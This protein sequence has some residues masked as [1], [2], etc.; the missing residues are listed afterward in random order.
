MSLCARQ[1]VQWLLALA[2]LA[3]VC[4]GAPGQAPPPSAPTTLHVK[5]SLLQIPV[6]ILGP[7]HQP[8]PPIDGS[9]FSVQLGGDKPFRPRIVRREG[10]DPI[11]LAIL[12]DGSARDS[13]V[14]EMAAA[15][16]ALAGRELHE[17]DRVAVYAMDGCK[18]RRML[19]LAEPNAVL[20]RSSVEAALT[21][22]PYDRYK[23][24][25]E[26]CDSP[27]GLWDSL[28]WVTRSLSGEPGRRV[29]LAVSNGV[30]LGSHVVPELLRLSATR[31]G[32]A[33]FS[34]AERYKVP[35]G[36]AISTGVFTAANTASWLAV[37]SEGSGGM[38][39][40]TARNN[41]PG[42]LERFVDLLRGRYIVEFAPPPGIGAGSHVIT[43]SCGQPHD[44]I[45]PAG[46][47]MPIDDP[48]T[49]D[50]NVVHGRLHPDTDG[51]ASDATRPTPARP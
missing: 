10:D 19:T 6:L 21:F 36:E 7:K 15:L 32:T 22:P 51:D 24:H 49:A 33:I 47:A 45:R 48:S 12:L 34:L 26:R 42:T 23:R 13:L 4:P 43:V 38:V 17:H 29:V 5:A 27:V 50:P 20:L 41:V 40:E 31:A 44:F 39:M 35:P 9:M 30:D 16:P 8:L 2:V 28:A 3:M 46:T 37:V 25:A 11:T 14:P 18:L 1:V